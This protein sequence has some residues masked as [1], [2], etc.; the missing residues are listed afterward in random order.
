MQ[1]TGEHAPEHLFGSRA[2][3]DR[4][5]E[6]HSTAVKSTLASG[7]LRRFIGASIYRRV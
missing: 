7:E 2:G 1:A 6:S 4:A 3:D 5:D